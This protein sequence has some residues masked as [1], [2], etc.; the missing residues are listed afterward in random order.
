MTNYIKQPD[1]E[2]GQYLEGN[3]EYIDQ[4][5]VFV[6]PYDEECA[7]EYRVSVTALLFDGVDEK[8]R[9]EIEG[10]I[11]YHVEVLHGAKNKLKMIQ[12]DEGLVPEELDV[13][14]DFALTPDD[15]SIK[16]ASI[17]R[18]INLDYLCYTNIEEE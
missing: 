16:D 3:R 18:K 1:N 13:P 5:H 2:L 6:D 10:V 4:L 7:E 11:Q 14:L 15:M 12:I 8:K 17:S 9:K